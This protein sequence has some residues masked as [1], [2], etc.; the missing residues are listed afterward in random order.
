MGVLRGP[1]DGFRTFGIVWANCT[2]CFSKAFKF[3]RSWG[4]EIGSH[5]PLQEIW[6][7]NEGEAILARRRVVPLI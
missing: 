4:F 5:A 7:S 1:R 6:E 3:Q 2:A